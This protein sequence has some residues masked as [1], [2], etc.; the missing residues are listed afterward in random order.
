M[1]AGGVRGTEAIAALGRDLADVA[2]AHGMEPATL[3]AILRRDDTLWVNAQ[4]KL[5]YIDTFGTLPVGDA[6]QS[7]LAATGSIAPEDAFTLHS[8]P[9][10]TK[11]IYLDF[12]GHHSVGSAWAHDI[13]FPAYDTSGDPS[14]FSTAE[15]NN[16]INWWRRV[17]E[18]FAPFDV[19]VTTEEPA[20]DA[21]TKTS[22]DDE[23]Y[24]VRCVIT[25]D[26]G[27]NAST[28]ASPTVGLSAPRW[29]RRSS[30]ST[31]ARP[32]ARSPVTRS[33]MPWA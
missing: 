26:D 2:A 15:L 20:T 16:I 25:Q 10:S 32:E 6:E 30:C 29:T 24:G 28:V 21:L 31:R 3:E 1:P 23:F 8:R 22:A 13:V 33:G 9:G 11:T 12:N 4:R 5:V 14:V 18:D 7:S 27:F 19:D 17:R